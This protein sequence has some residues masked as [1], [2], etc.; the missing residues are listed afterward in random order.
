MQGVLEVAQ[1]SKLSKSNAYAEGYGVFSLKGEVSNNLTAKNGGLAQLSGTAK[2]G[3]NAIAESGG[4][5]QILD[6]GTI[7]GG[8]TAKDSGIIQLGK[9]ESGTNTSGA[10]LATSSITLQNGGILAGAGTIEKGSEIHTNPQVKNE[11]GI[12]MAGFGAERV[13]NLDSTNN[14]LKINGSYTQ[15]TDF[16]LQIAFSGSSTLSSKQIAM[17]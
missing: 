17:I 1:N 7:I 5:V 2:V 13:T 3:K 16:T 10:T 8:I 14:T 15:N 4:I 11:G 6:S 9:V 12:V